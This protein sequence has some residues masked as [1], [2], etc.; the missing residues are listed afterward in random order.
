MP[1]ITALAIQEDT[2]AYASVLR[3]L[4]QRGYMPNYILAD[5][6]A[7]LTAAAKEVFPLALRQMCWVSFYLTCY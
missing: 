3:L 5:G 7:S 6:S 1:T 2:Y 4:R